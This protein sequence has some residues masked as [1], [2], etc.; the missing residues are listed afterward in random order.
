M[1][2]WR[3]R[4]GIHDA[5]QGVR[6]LDYATKIQ[7]NTCVPGHSCLF[8]SV[9]DSMRVPRGETELYEED[10]VVEDVPPIYN[11]RITSLKRVHSG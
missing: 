1:E 8:P 10:G 2:R 11:A 9:Q 4:V 7:Q 6:S 3:P 5:S